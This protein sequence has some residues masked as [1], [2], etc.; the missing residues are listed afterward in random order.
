MNTH[1]IKVQFGKHKGELWT[2]VP[3]SYLT[4]LI[5]EQPLNGDTS[6]QKIAKS[7]LER[8]GTT[9]KTDLDISGHA[10]DRASLRCRKIWH[11]TSLQD[12]G[13]Y[14]WLTR[15]SNE[16]LDKCEHSE[17]IKYNGLK[18]VFNY[19]NYYPTLKSVIPDKKGLNNE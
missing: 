3:R 18:L 10:I 13:I 11:Q 12:E 17:R 5:N 6:N 2:R 4:W 16:A 15:I 19:G 14:S 8:R 7:E 1:N 9:V